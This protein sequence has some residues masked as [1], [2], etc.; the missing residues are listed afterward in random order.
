MGA[1]LM[2]TRGMR[3]SSCNWF[4]IYAS[5]AMNTSGRTIENSLPGNFT[6]MT[7]KAPVGVVGGII[8]WNGPLIGQWWLFGPALATGCTVS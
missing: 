5:Q 4:N 2:R 1:P 8:P 3:I 7:L 6:T